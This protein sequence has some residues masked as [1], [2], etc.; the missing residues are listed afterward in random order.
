VSNP[1]REPIG[2]TARVRIAHS[3][4]DAARRAPQ[5]ATAHEIDAQTDIGEIY[6]AALVRS[7]RRL[8]VVVCAAVVVVL[9][10]IALAGAF[11]PRYASWRFLGLPV[12]WLVLG[13][14]VYPVLIALGW[15]AVRG[16]ERNENAFTELVRRR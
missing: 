12:P 6:M 14:V 7:Q 4:T 11:A 5:R 13:L 3:R 1:T 9:G 8:A 10:G 16:A 2:T 15:H